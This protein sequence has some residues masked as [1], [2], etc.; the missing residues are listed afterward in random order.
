MNLRQ[1][2]RGNED[3][4]PVFHFFR[5]FDESVEGKLSRN[6]VEKHVELIHHTERCFKALPNGKKQGKSGEASFTTAQC[7]DIFGLG[8]FI[9]VVLKLG[10]KQSK[11]NYVL[12]SREVEITL[13]LYVPSE[14]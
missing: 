7:L 9:I 13:D 5:Q 2:L 14:Q 12:Q 1:V 3:E 11:V 6:R 10:I 8:T 4:L